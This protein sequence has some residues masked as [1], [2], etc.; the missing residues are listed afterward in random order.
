MSIVKTTVFQTELGVL[1]AN[2]GGRTSIPN[3]LGAIV[4]SRPLLTNSLPTFSEADFGVPD[5]IRLI[6]SVFN[7]FTDTPYWCVVEP[8]V[9]AA[10][11]TSIK[12]VLLVWWAYFNS[13]AKEL[14][15][16]IMA[17]V[18]LYFENSATV[19]EAN[20]GS[21]FSS[22][23]AMVFSEEALFLGKTAAL[24]VTMATG[25][26]SFF[27]GMEPKAIASAFES[28]KVKDMD[29]PSG[30][31]R[32]FGDLLESLTTGS[33]GLFLR[34]FDPT[35]FKTGVLGDLARRTFSLCAI[36]EDQLGYADGKRLPHFDAMR[37]SHV[38]A[39]NAVRSELLAVSKP[40]AKD[41]AYCSSLLSKVDVA[42]KHYESPAS[43]IRRD[44]PLS[45]YLYGDPGVG[46]TSIG[47]VVISSMAEALGLDPTSTTEGFI[48]PNAKYADT[49][50]HNPNFITCDEFGSVDYRDPSVSSA[51]ASTFLNQISE[52]PWQPEFAAVEDKGTQLSPNG[53]LFMGNGG[54]PSIQLGFSDPGA[55]YRR[56]VCVHLRVKDEYKTP[57]GALDSAKAR[58]PYSEPWDFTIH[59]YAQDGGNNW[60]P[61][62]SRAF[63]SVSSFRAGLI[64][65]LRAMHARNK[66]PE[67]C[68]LCLI[69]LN[70]VHTGCAGN[71]ASHAVV[72]QSDLVEYIGPL[73]G[74]IFG[75][76]PGFNLFFYFIGVY[77][78]A[79]FANIVIL[80]SY[81]CYQF[82]GVLPRTAWVDR[83]MATV[84]VV[85]QRYLAVQDTVH[86]FRVRLD[87]IGSVFQRYRYAM[88]GLLAAGALYKITRVLLAVKTVSEGNFLSMVSGTETSSVARE[89]GAKDAY[90]GSSGLP[91]SGPARLVHG[92]KDAV[93]RAMQ[94]VIYAMEVEAEGSDR[95]AVAH[96]FCIN[97]NG[98]ASNSHLFKL[99]SPTY[100]VKISVIGA[101]FPIHWSGTVTEVRRYPNDLCLF[102]ADWAQ[103]GP[104]FTHHLRAMVPRVRPTL[105]FPTDNELQLLTSPETSYGYIHH[106][107]QGTGKFQAYSYGNHS[108]GF[109]GLPLWDFADPAEPI[110]VG[111]HTA[112]DGERG[113]AGVVTQSFIDDVAML[114]RKSIPL[115]PVSSVSSRA[116]VHN[117]KEDPNVVT[118][119][120]QSEAI[121]MTLVG[122]LAR[123][124]PRVETAFV[125]TSFGIAPIDS[126]FHTK[127]EIPD[128]KPKLVD[129]KW[130]SCYIDWVRRSKTHYNPDLSGVV[131]FVKQMLTHR[132][133]A[134]HVSCAFKPADLFSA[135]NGDHFFE[136][137]NFNTSGGYQYTGAKS[138]YFIGQPGSRMP[139]ARL[140]EQIAVW[141][142]AFRR[143]ENPGV[144][145]DA[146]P[147]DEPK[148]PGKVIRMIA[149]SPL[150]LTILMRVY[151]L[152]VFEFM[153]Q[154][155]SVFGTAPGVNCFSNDWAEMWAQVTFGD[156]ATEYV[157]AGDFKEFDLHQF[158]TLIHGAFA[159]LIWIAQTFGT[160]TDDD[161]TVMWAMAEATCAHYIS[162][163]PEV[164][165]RVGANPSG[166]GATTF[167]NCICNLILHCLALMRLGKTPFWA[168]FNFAYFF[169]GDDCLANTRDGSLTQ[170]VMAAVCSSYG[171]I[172]TDANKNDELPDYTG[173][174]AT[175]LKRSFVH[176]SDLGCMVAPIE[177]PS[178][179]KML[180]WR[181]ARSALDVKEW[182]SVVS[183]NALL[184]CALHGREV[185]E[186][187][188]ST[189]PSVPKHCGFSY[190][191]CLGFYRDGRYHEW[192][193]A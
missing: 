189:Y 94:T 93:L 30:W 88:V 84:E 61:S 128:L 32:G 44:V 66:V 170:K 137:L 124:M 144:V 55:M 14:L 105:V 164:F 36:R 110:L 152:P 53:C 15:G 71:H 73:A 163:G 168:A 145:F 108:P 155:R 186:L 102:V 80:L 127:T 38:A 46:K 154:H 56:F 125:P 87:H 190:E 81:I 27:L 51:I 104:D 91:T 12:D 33:L 9:L 78:M 169:M 140:S 6:S 76:M 157:I 39:L 77:L 143:G 35:V 165:F 68:P 147:K 151:F 54:L 82:G 109:C 131:E 1:A 45:V 62:R 17:W 135:I 28:F 173:P 193:W 18:S 176:H 130:Q 111:F 4:R 99:G 60:V 49:L 112:G 70:M 40:T 149:A 101:K 166:Q 24:V 132:I 95:V 43:R 2:L 34:T 146:F 90:F 183:R 134:Q 20:F 148:K 106:V 75:F 138:Q 175:F 188:L 178:V 50:A 174:T 85:R 47:R 74:F 100:R 23:K 5:V 120:T 21:T 185:F 156:T 3:S 42:L 117:L 113:F 69:P 13:S 8:L 48:A 26:A 133:N 129:G 31:L 160:Y 167:V 141:R 136:P 126:P 118:S 16:Y 191:D 179:G 162:I 158:Y 19:S 79:F 122:S 72:A 121:N 92:N 59:Y 89:V 161:I 182:E 65:E 22:L 7:N 139:C 114:P 86:R 11:C 171:F 142:E 181:N 25:G 119:L 180:A 29:T 192:V 97:G 159:I 107:D 64:D 10:S 96:C 37:Q 150:P 184:E 115:L 63:S 172:Y 187:L 123:A 83:Q 67:P 58:E 41:I 57:V 116:F 103:P 177:L 52:M 153:H 98:F